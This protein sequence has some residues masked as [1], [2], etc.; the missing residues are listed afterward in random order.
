MSER[1]L[2]ECS[3]RL[4]T[5]SPSWCL[6]R[7]L[8][9]VLSSLSTF[10]PESTLASSFQ[11]G[12]LED[13]MADL[14]SLEGFTIPPYPTPRRYHSETQTIRTDHSVFILGSSLGCWESRCTA[15]W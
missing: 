12:S 5:P 1:R 9:K 11:N 4:M 14:G 8:E 7:R 10:G 3:L 6:L 15:S 13:I 2:V